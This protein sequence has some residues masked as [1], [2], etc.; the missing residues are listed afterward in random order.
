MGQHNEARKATQSVPTPS[1]FNN[2][3]ESERIR[4]REKIADPQYSK[5]KAG[6]EKDRGRNRRF[7]ADA[8][9]ILEEEDAS[10]M[11]AKEARKAKKAKRKEKPKDLVPIFLPQFISVENL[12]SM[13]NVRVEHFAKQLRDMGFTE[14]NNDHVL[15]SEEAGLIAG[16]YGYE[17]VIDRGSEIDLKPR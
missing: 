15:G 9:A 2:Y 16:E 10:S 8:S 5:R 12:A 11:T 1:R 17:P 4:T 7:D 3:D 14:T 6:K 13:L